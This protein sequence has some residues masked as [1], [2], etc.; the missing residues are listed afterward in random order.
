MEKTIVKL[1]TDFNN[2]SVGDIFMEAHYIR[3]DGAD[4][5]YEQYKSDEQHRI[6][7]INEFVLDHEL[8][9]MTICYS[10]IINETQKDQK[11]YYSISMIFQFK[12]KH[13][14]DKFGSFIEILT[15]DEQW[16]DTSIA[17]VEKSII[18]YC[19]SY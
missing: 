15:N 10:L 2:K 19:E 1:V 12:E 17:G 14:E 16:N 5:E 13:I 6:D 8:E 7:G 11:E 4:R 18:F 9:S 3:P